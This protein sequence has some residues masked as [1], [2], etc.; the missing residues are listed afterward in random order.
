MWANNKKKKIS[1]F[2]KSTN[3]KKKWFIFLKQKTKFHRNNQRLQGSTIIL[4]SNKFIKEQKGTKPKYMGNIKELS[5]KL[6]T[7]ITDI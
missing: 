1:L 3:H 2:S 5:D 6:R 7:K 4:I